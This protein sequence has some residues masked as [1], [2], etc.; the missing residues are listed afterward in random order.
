MPTAA[1][2]AGAHC[3]TLEAA[4][5]HGNADAVR[6]A[7]VPVPAGLRVLLRELLH[8]HPGTGTLR[9][10]QVWQGVQELTSETPH[11]AKTATANEPTHRSR[12]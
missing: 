3:V 7:C 10:R 12:N 5:R 9:T 6:Q 11:A 8:Y 1:G 4:L 2:L